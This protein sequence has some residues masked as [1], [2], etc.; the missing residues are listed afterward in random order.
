MISRNQPL[1]DSVKFKG[2]AA[3]GY[4]EFFQTPRGGT[5]TTS[6]AT[7]ASYK[8]QDYHSNVK[9][10]G[11]TEQGQ[12]LKADGISISFDTLDPAVIKSIA[13]DTQALVEVYVKDICVLAIP[14]YKMMNFNN[15][16]VGLSA[17]ATYVAQLWGKSN[18][19]YRFNDVGVMIDSQTNFKVKII[20]AAALS[21]LTAY[22]NI[23]AMLHGV[24]ERA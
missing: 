15:G 2:C 20:F 13:I 21:D 17:S 7:P 1:W 8:K 24:E 9:L 23:F 22:V 19:Y 12:V 14:L 16:M 5:A 6:E 3:N 18:D 11:V 10:A 4:I